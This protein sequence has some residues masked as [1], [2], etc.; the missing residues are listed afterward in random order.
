[1]VTYLET[2]GKISL[3][4]SDGGDGFDWKRV[5]N[6]KGGSDGTGLLLAKGYFDEVGYNKMG[7]VVTAV[8]G[9]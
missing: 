5:G 4:I 3:T 8:L 1:M 9:K 6:K 7:N 2:E